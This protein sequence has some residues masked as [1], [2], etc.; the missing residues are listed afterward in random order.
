MTK[1]TELKVTEGLRWML[2]VDM[3]IAKLKRHDQALQ[4]QR[5]LVERALSSEGHLVDVKS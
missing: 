2:A 1:E 5:N 4:E 3:L